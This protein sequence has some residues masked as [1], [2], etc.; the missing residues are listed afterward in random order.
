MYLDLDRFKE[1]N[2]TLGHHM[3]DTLLKEVASRLMNC[4]RAD[5]TVARMGGDEFTM[6]LNNLNHQSHTER[7]AQ[8]ILDKLAEPFN[9][10]GEVI[11]I[12]ASV[13]ISIY[14]TNG[15]EVEVLLKNADH[16]MY[17]AKQNGR[18]RY[19]YYTAEMQQ[20]LGQ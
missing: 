15:T 14:P 19:H 17:F 9:L 11:H 13:G 20:N 6:I 7:I 1:V 18:N 5:D 8:S 16:A 3:G 2:D 4:V 12:S 10:G